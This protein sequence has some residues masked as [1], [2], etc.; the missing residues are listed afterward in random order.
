MTNT[1]FIE[2]FK[3][4]NSWNPSTKFLVSATELMLRSFVD[5]SSEESFT[6]KDLLNEESMYYFW[7]KFPPSRGGIITTLI[8]SAEDRRSWWHKPHFNQK[9]AVDTLNFI[10]DAV[11]D[12]DNC[13]NA[14]LRMSVGRAVGKEL[15]HLSKIHR[16]RLLND[17]EMYN[18]WYHD[19]IHHSKDPKFFDFAFSSIK[20]APGSTKI[21]IDIIEYAAQ[22]DA[23]G[24]V[25]ITTVAKRGTKTQ[26]RA[27]VS[28]LHEM[29]HSLKRVI[30]RLDS[31][32]PSYKEDC[33]AAQKDI[34]DMEARL[35][36]FVDCDDANVVENLMGV[37]SKDNLPWLMPA[38]SK[39]HYLSSRLQRIIERGDAY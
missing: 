2:S 35:M 34:D 31:N 3:F 1:V 14:K 26:K 16:Y 12:D 22:N 39:N 19:G 15:D 29:M 10:Y 32:S 5:F 38:A 20:R 8:T 28:H 11:P 7:N 25:T 30:R 33:A 9:F 6:S 27:V 21:K 36:M 24:D 37:L 23:L 18:V 13:D 17:D 4:K